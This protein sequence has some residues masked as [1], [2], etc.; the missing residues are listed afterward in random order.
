VLILTHYTLIFNDGTIR[1]Y[2][3][4]LVRDFTMLGRDDDTLG[5]T[6]PMLILNNA[7]IIQYNVLTKTERRNANTVHR[8]RKDKTS[9][10]QRLNIVFSFS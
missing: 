6:H 5:L 4:T 7:T 10:K 8:L 2:I 9:T 3:D 1:Q